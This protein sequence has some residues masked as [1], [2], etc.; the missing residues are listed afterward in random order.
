MASA[1]LFHIVKNHAFLDGNKRT[2]LLAALV[3]LKLNGVNV[4]DRDSLLYDVTIAVAEGRL[5]KDGLAA[6]LRDL[7]GSTG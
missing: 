6:I 5:D 1:Y 2:G 3:F 7:S 4:V